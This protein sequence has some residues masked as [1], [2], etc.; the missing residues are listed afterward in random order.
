MINRFLLWLLLILIFPGEH[1]TLDAQ[2]IFNVKRTFTETDH[3]IIYAGFTSDGKYIVTTGSDNNIIIWNSESGIIYRTLVGLKKRPNIAQYSVEKNILISAGEDNT[4]TLWDP[5]T[6]KT[7][8]TFT[9]HHGPVKSLDISPDGKYLATGSADCTIRI[10][11]IKSGNPVYELKG[12]KKDVNSIQFSP[13]GKKLISGS[14]DGTIII[15]SLANGNMINKKEAHKGWIRCIRFSQDGKFIAS[16]GDDKLIQI[17]SFPELNSV[18]TLK[19]HKDWVQSI[20]FTP[21]GKNLISGGHDQLIILWEVAT[22]KILYQSEKQG[23]IVLSID[24]CPDRPDFI[25][26]C[27]LSEDLKIWALSGLDEA[28]W[29]IQKTSLQPETEITQVENKVIDSLKAESTDKEQGMENL[30]LKEEIQNTYPLIEIYSPA[31]TN[32]SANYDQPVITIIGRIN[33]PEGINAFL[34]N[35]TVVKL[36]DAGVFQFN[37]DLIKGKNTI[38]LVAI[39]NG[40]KMNKRTVVVECTSENASSEKPKITDIQKGKYYA[41]I[42]GIDEYKDEGIPDLD[43]PISDAEALYN[44][45]VSHYTFEKEN[46]IFLKNPILDEMILA[47]DELGRK[48][49]VDDNL[50]MFYAGHGH[51]DDKGK[52]GYW[53]PSDAEM[54]NTVK[55]FRNSTLRDFIGSIQTRHTFLIADACFSGAI[56][57]TRSGITEPSQGIQK[58]YELPS[59]KAMTSGILQQVPDE[60]VFIKYLVK[61]LEENEEKYLSSEE[62]FSSFKTAV[63][64]NSPNVPQFGTI[65]NVGDEGGDFIFIT[66]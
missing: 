42:I 57:K 65:Q 62:L 49:T 23:Q 36:S 38:E 66:R 33:D 8:R 60:S 9:G 32:N 28:Q 56:F 27:L 39:N 21:D 22:G 55:W 41:L 51:W 61:R 25:S 64:N 53:L 13:D 40:G 16:C 46:I 52:L 43:N 10:W 5:V 17:W 58:L 14:A 24:I 37:L 19:G 31:F 35:N 15:W 44:V 1:L 45:L 6:L 18:S 34:I 20:D 12:H 47:L 3:Q 48:L 11:D 29:K 59:R 26:T 4:A 54:Y 50:L 2:F 63:M 30:N 7:T